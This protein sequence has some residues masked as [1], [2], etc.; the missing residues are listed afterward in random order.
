M[1][2][3][4]PGGRFRPNRRWHSHFQRRRF[5]SRGPLRSFAE[6]RGI[7]RS[8]SGL[9]LGVCKGLANYFDLPV[10]LVRILTIV[11]FFI[12][13]F[14]PVGAGYLLLGLLLKPEPVV[15]P[16]D[17]VEAEFYNS[18]AESRSMALGRLK[19]TYE[20]LERRLRRLEDTVTSRDFSWDQRAGR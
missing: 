11:G 12:S 16:A 7:Y 13:G 19:D 18:Y 14:W 5:H 1:F 17:E 2:C 6:R 4:G 15:V 8:R 10:P 3:C 20:R 9:I